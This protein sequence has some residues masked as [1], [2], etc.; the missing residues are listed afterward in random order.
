MAAKKPQSN[1]KARTSAQE[2]RPGRPRLL[3]T[4]AVVTGASR[5]I[6]FAIARTLASEGCSV[7]I[8]GRDAAALSKSAAELRRVLPKQTPARDKSGAQIVAEVCDVR[9]ADSI[10]ALFA[11]VKQRLSRLDVL[12]NNAGSPQ[13]E[14]RIGRTGLD[15]RRE[16][17][18]TN[19][20]GL[21]GSTS[22]A[23]AIM[24]AGATKFTS[25]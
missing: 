8:T 24:D 17:I 25:L 15:I 2:S 11:M 20:A 10:A 13:P 4:V 22:E 7:V 6:G 18:D 23:L 14:V 19:L 9:D 21:V 5:G 12:V 1:S 3:G 16:A